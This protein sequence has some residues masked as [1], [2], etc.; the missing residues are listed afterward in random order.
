MKDARGAEDGAALRGLLQEH[1]HSV[2]VSVREKRQKRTIPFEEERQRLAFMQRIGPAGKEVPSSPFARV[3]AR[4]THCHLAS[5]MLTSC[6]N[7]DDR[8]SM[9]KRL[10]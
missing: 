3:A 8:S 10:S 6:A 4:L 2:S 5:C 7:I 9:A 1:Y